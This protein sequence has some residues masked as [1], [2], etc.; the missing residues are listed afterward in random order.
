MGIPSSLSLGTVPVLQHV[1]I[2]AAPPAPPQRHNAQMR[3]KKAPSA[4]T[5]GTLCIIAQLTQ[6]Q[7]QGYA[8]YWERFWH[9]LLLESAYG[10]VMTGIRVKEGGWWNAPVWEST[11]RFRCLDAEG[12]CVCICVCLHVPECAE[13]AE[14]LC[15]SRW[16]VCMLEWHT[17]VC[18]CVRTCMR[19]CARV[20]VC[21]HARVE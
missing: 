18:V 19:V 9:C 17:F 2:I 13:V 4:T 15:M 5:A 21:V 11:A 8:R 12:R 16:S 10:V 3:L 1:G 14:S 20:C 6:S 7:A